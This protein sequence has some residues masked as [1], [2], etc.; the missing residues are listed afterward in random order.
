MDP[1]ETKISNLLHFFLCFFLLFSHEPRWCREC[2]GDLL[3]IVDAARDGRGPVLSAVNSVSRTTDRARVGCR[4][5][6]IE[7]FHPE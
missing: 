3:Y 4:A 2:L 6:L 7:M 1:V 5:V